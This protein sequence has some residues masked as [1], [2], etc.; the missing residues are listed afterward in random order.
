MADDL[1]ASERGVHDI[2]A[3]TSD[4]AI[5][6][7]WPLIAQLRPHLDVDAL[8]AQL[9]R[10]FAEGFRANVLYDDGTPRAY[11]GWR[12]H[13]NLV[14]GPHMYV[15]DLV[16]DETVRSRGYGKAMLDW[17]K[18]EAKRL[19]C[20]KLQLDSGTFRKDAHAFYLRE[21]LRI[22]A[23]HFGIALD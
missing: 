5:R 9:Q 4:T 12:V 7:A 20:S 6:A 19:G 8:A 22:E 18:L 1:R 21:G 14:Y 13:E 15:D 17:L 23:F 2:R 16:T 10:Q 11:A 3:L